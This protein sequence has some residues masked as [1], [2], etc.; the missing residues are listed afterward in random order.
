[1]T[2]GAD[3]DRRR[4]GSLELSRGP[5]TLLWYRAMAEYPRPDFTVDVVLL[6]WVRR[7]ELLLIERRK[8][9]F[10]GRW[11]LP[12]GYVEKDE[13]ARAAAVRELV[14]ETAVT[15]PSER[16]LEIGVFSEPGRDP[17]GW[18]ISSA[19]IGLAP[20]D[21]AARAGDDA[22]AARWHP[23]AELPPLAFDH[24]AI[25][26]AGLARLRA[27]LQVDTV[28]LALLPAG[29]RSADA[30][31]LY[32]ALIGED[33]PPRKFKAW[34]RRREAVVRIG[35]SRFIPSAGLTADWLR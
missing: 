24:A 14:E 18:T 2:H 7:L 28:A 27:H 34:L 30:R 29:F 35:P 26:S 6:R 22:A 31:R 20:S 15:F 8:D 9:P 5:R 3:L 12:G 32:G 17:R 16:L 33:I 23:V 21:T 10:A 1:M 25:V 4:P 11:A 13:P 19:W